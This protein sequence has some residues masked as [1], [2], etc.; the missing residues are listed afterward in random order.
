MANNTCIDFGRSFLCSDG[1]R[2]AGRKGHENDNSPIN[3]QDC[4]RLWVESAL[5]I[6]DDRDGTSKAIYQCGSC[7]AEN[8][9]DAKGPGDLF[10]QPNYD[11]IPVLHGSEI[12]IF[13]RG[14]YCD[15]ANGPPYTTFEMQNPSFGSF[16][17]KVV[18]LEDIEL[19]NS[20]EKIVQA[21]NRGLPMVGKT[22]LS[23]SKTQLRAEIQ[24]PIKSLNIRFD[25]DIYQIDTGPVLFPDLSKRYENWAQQ[26]SLACVA[27]E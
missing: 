19:L 20:F 13:R 8:T 23:S 10:K 26:V 5:R 14:S 16:T 18:E 4:V 17:H 24:Y 25:P 12:L 7:K 3:A 1:N 9:F 11:F 21:S 2:I 6:F 22:L 15:D 27:Y